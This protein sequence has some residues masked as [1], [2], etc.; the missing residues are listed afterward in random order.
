MNAMELA[1]AA[2]MKMTDKIR[3][4]SKKMVEDVYFS[5]NF[6]APVREQYPVIKKKITHMLNIY[7]RERL[8]FQT[9]IN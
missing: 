8:L 1:K 7:F 2:G 6:S 5:E 9:A 4:V 3:I